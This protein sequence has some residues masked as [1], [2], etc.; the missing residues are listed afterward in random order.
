LLGEQM[1]LDLGEIKGTLADLEARI[2]KLDRWTDIG[3]DD[4]LPS[5]VAE[6]M[7]EHRSSRAARSRW[8]PLGR[9]VER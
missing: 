9:H 4:S 6:V 2:A 7:G 1:Q 5:L 3:S 8:L